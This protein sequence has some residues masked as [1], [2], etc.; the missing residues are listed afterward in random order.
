ML[1]ISELFVDDVIHHKAPSGLQ[2][3]IQ[4][5]NFMAGSGVLASILILDYL[6]EDEITDIHTTREV[7]CSY[8]PEISGTNHQI[9]DINHKTK[10]IS[11][12]KDLAASVAVAINIYGKLVPL[13]R[14]DAIL[15]FFRKGR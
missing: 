9:V 4:S 2:Y 5:V 12:T 3:F 10:Y 13:T 1:L 15:E 11:I 7:L 8:S 14:T 6:V